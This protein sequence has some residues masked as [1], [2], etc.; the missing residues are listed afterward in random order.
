MRS[1]MLSGG[2][3]P[4]PPPSPFA[5]LFALASEVPRALALRHKKV[6][7]SRQVTLGHGRSR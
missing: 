1:G 7:I 5:K 4:L 3:K 6:E 2:A